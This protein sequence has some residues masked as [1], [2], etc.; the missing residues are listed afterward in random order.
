MDCPVLRLNNKVADLGLAPIQFL[1]GNYTAEQAR[2]SAKTAVS[3]QHVTL[4]QYR[5]DPSS[6]C[7]GKNHFPST[8]VPSNLRTGFPESP[9]YFAHNRLA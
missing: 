2:R 9:Q 8:Q 1:R 3:V 4:S 5:A 7:S 6:I